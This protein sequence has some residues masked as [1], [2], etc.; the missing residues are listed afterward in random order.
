MS[1]SWSRCPGWGLGLRMAV[2]L[3]AH[4]SVGQCGGAMGRWMWGWGGWEGVGGVWGGYTVRT[5]PG[6][7]RTC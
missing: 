1:P 4:P 3:S 5:P 6:L 7:G 2:G